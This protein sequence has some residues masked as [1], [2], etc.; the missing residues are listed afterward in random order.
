L[1][2][3]ADLGVGEPEPGAESQRIREEDEQQSA[4][5]QQKQQ[6]EGVPVIEKLLQTAPCF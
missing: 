6:P 1:A 5:G 3:A 2:G 4:R